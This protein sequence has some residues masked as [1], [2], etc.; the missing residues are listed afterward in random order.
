VSHFDKSA[1]H[2]QQL[3][4]SNFPHESYRKGQLDAIE[5]IAAAFSDGYKYVVLDAPTGSGKSAINTAFA[6]TAKSCF[7]TTPQNSLIDQIAND[8]VLGNYYEELK[9]KSH[10]E[11]EFKDCRIGEPGIHTVELKV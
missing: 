1:S 4:K 10:Y 5:E 3:V 8:G 9:G 7:Y 2:L 11:C 6:R